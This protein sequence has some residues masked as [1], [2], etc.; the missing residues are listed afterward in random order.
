MATITKQ[1]K[2]IPLIK[3]KSREIIE[4]LQSGKIY[5]SC[6]K[7]F[8]DYENDSGDMVIGDSLE[9][10]LHVVDGTMINKSTGEHLE[11]SKSTLYTSASNSFVYCMSCINPNTERFEYS[12]LQKK[13]FKEFGDTALVILDSA[14]FINR[15]RKAATDKGY[16]I[17]FDRVHYYDTNI[18]TVDVWLSMFQGIHN[19]AFWKRKEYEHQQEFRMLIPADNCTDDHIELDI[20]DISDISSIFTTEQVLNGIVERSDE[21]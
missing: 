18:D 21:H 6:L 17:Y 14:D 4:S 15:V 20:G 16:T 19:I 2:G 11:L 9:G 7:W 3:F 13:D 1:I 8:R 12:E 10:M 5:L